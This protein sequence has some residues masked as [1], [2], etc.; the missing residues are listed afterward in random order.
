MPMKHLL[1]HLVTGNTLSTEQAVEAFELIM[2]GQAT[3][4]QTGALLAMIEHRGATIDEIVGAATVMRDKVKCVTVPAG[5]RVIDTCG[6]G[7]D[8]AG[9]FNISTA[10]AL[11]AAGAGKPQGIAVA[12]HGNRSV[13]SNSG[14]SQVLDTLGV[15][16]Q[17]TPDTLSRCL[18]EAGLCFCFAPSHHPAMKHAAPIRAELGFRTLFNVLGP[19]T[20]P[21]GATRQV[22]GVFATQMTKPIANV[23]ARLGADH[24][25]VVHGQIP[26]DDGKHV[27]GLD[28]LSTCG[29]SQI[30]EVRDGKVKTYEIDPDD[31]GLSYSHPKALKVDSPERSAAVIRELLEGEVGPPRDIVM[32]NAAAALVVAELA[33]DL[34]EGLEL[35]RESIDSGAAKQ[36]LDRLVEITTADPTPVG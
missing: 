31:L 17:V 26:D 22:I 15:K 7:G 21:A 30:S 1:A 11:V 35:A 25:M 28:E 23:L 6:T 16:L 14:S 32:L 10:A 33:E 36:A 18:E 12:K 9:T 24:A 3:P 19:L 34:P 29:P 2:T 13:T 8:H 20:N 4:A 27:D 5:L